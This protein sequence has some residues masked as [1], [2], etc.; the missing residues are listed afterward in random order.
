[1]A[2]HPLGVLD[3]IGRFGPTLHL[4]LGGGGGGALDTKHRDGVNHSYARHHTLG[5]VDLDCMFKSWMV[6][7]CTAVLSP[8]AKMLQ[9]GLTSLIF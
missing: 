4:F 1:M 9:V 8:L 3:L 6:C 7:V 5:A 2:A